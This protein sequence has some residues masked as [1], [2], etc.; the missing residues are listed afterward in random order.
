MLNTLSHSVICLSHQRVDANKDDV[1]SGLGLSG[2]LHY[3]RQWVLEIKGSSLGN[4]MLSARWGVAVTEK[5]AVFIEFERQEVEINY[6][7]F[8]NEISNTIQI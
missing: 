3:N 2:V 8:L 5:K 6:M 1:L 4:S 7:N